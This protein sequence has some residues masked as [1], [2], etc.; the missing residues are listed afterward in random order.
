MKA[1]EE[2]ANADIA[3]TK[4]SLMTTISTSVE[5]MADNIFLVVQEK[6]GTIADNYLSLKA[7]AIAAA[8]LVED[9]LKKGK[10]RNLG[11]IGDLLDTLAQMSQMPPKME[12]GLGFDLDEIP[13]I[14]SG[15]MV[16]VDGSV[17]KINGLVDEYIRTLGQ[18]KSR[19]PMGLGYYLI[20][21]LEL[22]MQ[23]QGALE[24]DKVDGKSGNFVFVNGHSLGLSSRLS[25]FEQLSVRMHEY[26]GVLSHLTATLSGKKTA[27]KKAKIYVS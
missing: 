8:D 3:V 16:P 14:F 6:R 1:V 15:E 24:V 19:W 7:Y 13:K 18:I 12:A 9:Y 2:R 23:N 20:A 21:Q 22:A 10:G 25:D 11:S 27:G 17:S 4:K 5:N 26:E